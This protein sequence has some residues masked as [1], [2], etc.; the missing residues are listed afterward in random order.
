[1]FAH[2]QC[3]GGACEESIL[4][5][6]KRIGGITIARA[7]NTINYKTSNP[8][9]NSISRPRQRLRNILCTR[10]RCLREL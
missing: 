3:G 6:S 1:M 7:V 5:F 4:S 8:L 10:Y 2:V 9:G